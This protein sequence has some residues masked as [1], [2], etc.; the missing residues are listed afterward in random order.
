MGRLKQL[1]P[2]VGSL[3]ARVTSIGA[4]PDRLKRR[5]QIVPWRKWYKTAEWQRLRWDCL[6]SALFTCARCGVIGQSRE[7][8][9][10]HIRPHRGDRDLF[11]DPGNLQCLCATCHNRDK[12]AEERAG[13]ANH[14]ATNG[15]VGRG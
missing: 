14:S 7:L 2:R 6:A 3:S 11:F 15:D 10:D 9:A 1:A 12:Q 5:D 8:V 13:A 4:G